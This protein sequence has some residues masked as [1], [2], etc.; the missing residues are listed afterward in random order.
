M[1]NQSPTWTNLPW[2]IR[3]FSSIIHLGFRSSCRSNGSINRRLI[4]LFEFQAPTPSTKP[5]NGIKTFDVHI[6][7]S[8]N[9]WFRFY[10]PCRKVGNNKHGGNMPLIIYFHGGGFAWMA[11]NSLGFD[12]LCRRFAKELRSVVISMNYRLAPEQSIHASF[13]MD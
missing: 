12:N 10:I 13:R 4:N 3:L 7:P 8:R 2:T 11:S 1:P 6:D 5:I 9:I